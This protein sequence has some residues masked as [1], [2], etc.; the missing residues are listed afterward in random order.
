MALLCNISGNLQVSDISSIASISWKVIEIVAFKLTMPRSIIPIIR[1][2]H[3]LFYIYTCVFVFVFILK[4]IDGESAPK[5][6]IWIIQSNLWYRYI[7]AYRH[8]LEFM[9]LLQCNIISNCHQVNFDIV[10]HFFSFW[11]QVIKHIEHIIA[12]TGWVSYNY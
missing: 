3:K 7:C 8:L 10:W 5:L 2:W 1:S 9:Y 11:F 4:P 6:H 12:G